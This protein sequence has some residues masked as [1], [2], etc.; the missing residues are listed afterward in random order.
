VFSNSTTVRIL[1][2]SAIALLVVALCP[3]KPPS[4]PLKV[5]QASTIQQQENCIQL[6]RALFYDPILSRDSTISCASCH[7]SYVAFTHVDHK[8]SHGIDDRIGRRNAPALMNLAWSKSFMWDGAINHLDMQALAPITNPLEMDEQLPHVLLKLQASGMYRR[9]FSE[10]F[11]DSLATTERMLKSLAA[12]LI[13]LESNWSKYD[14]VQRGEALFSE[15][16]ERGYQLFKQQCNSCHTEPLFTNGGFRSNGIAL[17]GDDFGRGEITG[18]ASDSGLFKVPTLRNIFY[19]RPYMHDGRMARLSDLML[20]YGLASFETFASSEMKMMK[21]MNEFQRI[22]ITAF[23]LTLSDSA[24]VFEKK[25]QYPFK[26]YEEF[27]V[28]P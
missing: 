7:S 6:G 28:Q 23:L 9:L 22:D 2:L 20:H 25:H 1:A 10:V 27:G 11:G 26:L 16:E 4:W 8:V 14:A 18:I 15:Q 3:S 24:F 17:S 13:T 19:S 21:P 12:F 5:Y